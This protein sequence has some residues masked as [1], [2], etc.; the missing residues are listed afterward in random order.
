MVS[1]SDLE[2]LISPGRFATFVRL[3]NADRSLAVDLYEWT[4]AVAGALFADF[5]T[6]EVVFRNHI[7]WALRSYVASV[8]PHVQHWM[9]DSC[10]I[11]PQGHWWDED[12]K[13]ALGAARKRAGG[14]KASRGAVIAEVT[15][16]FWRYIVSGRY[17]ESFWN[18]ALDNAF[19]NIPGHAPGDRRRRLEQSMINLLGLRNRLAHHE[20]IAKPWTRKL[21]GGRAGT[22]TLDDLYDDLVRVL[23]WTSPAHASSLLRT[24][25]VPRLLAARPC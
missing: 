25:R 10:W 20:P 23:R 2:Q 16:G 18:T 3:A 11:P 7:D 5:R 24:S 8:A 22:F 6:L 14:R 21:P 12:A 17:E 15:F 9:W 19:T 13:E 4:G 1:P